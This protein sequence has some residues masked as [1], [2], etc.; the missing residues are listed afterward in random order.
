MQQQAMQ[1][2]A[3]EHCGHYGCEWIHIEHKD[4]YDYQCPKCGSADVDHV[5][6]V[7]KSLVCRID[8]LEGMLGDAMEKINGS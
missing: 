4:G 5:D 3:C 8:L 6:I 7:L 1:W 2:Q